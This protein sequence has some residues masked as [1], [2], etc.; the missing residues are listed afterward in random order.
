M[1]SS[2]QPVTLKDFQNARTTPEVTSSYEIEQVST[3]DPE[4]LQILDS[5]DTL[6]YEIIYQDNDDL[7]LLRDA[8]IPAEFLVDSADYHYPVEI[9]LVP[10]LEQ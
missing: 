4:F 6:L 8:V 10:Y 3:S 7:I 2:K 9:R 5:G 1:L